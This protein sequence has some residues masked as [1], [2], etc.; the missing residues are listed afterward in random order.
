MQIQQGRRQVEDLIDDH[1]GTDRDSNC[2]DM[3][4]G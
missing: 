1:N 4:C 2:L 3:Q